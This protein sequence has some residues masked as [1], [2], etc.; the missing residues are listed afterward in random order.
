M[1]KYIPY[2][3]LSKKGSDPTAAGGGYREGSEW[4]RSARCKSA[5]SDAASAGHRNREQRKLDLARRNTWGELNPATRKPE[6]SKTY[7]RNKARNWK[8]DYHETNSGIFYFPYFSYSPG[9]ICTRFRYSTQQCSAMPRAML[10]VIT[11]FRSNG[12]MVLPSQKRLMRTRPS[13][14]CL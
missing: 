4:Q 2:E 11:I 5:L 6:N 10:L 3:K 14:V 8:R 9:R 13:S 12:F 7:N 1:K